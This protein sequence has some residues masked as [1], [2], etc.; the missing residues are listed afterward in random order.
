VLDLAFQIH[1]E[2]FHFNR[3]SP[4][5]SWFEA[6][7]AATAGFWQAWAD[8]ACLHPLC[9]RPA[10]LVSSKITEFAFIRV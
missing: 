5:G 4:Y 2:T 7:S 3:H 6:K 8:A 1:Q 9:R 10:G